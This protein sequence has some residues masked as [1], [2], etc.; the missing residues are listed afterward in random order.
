MTSGLDVQLSRARTC[1]AIAIA[2]LTALL[3]LPGSAHA[4][5]T[6]TWVAG[7]GD[8]A[9]P[10]SRTAPCKTW[11]GAISKTATGGEI[12]ALNPGGFGA[13][14]ITKSITLSAT[15]VT[16]SILVSGT[17]GIVIQAPDN[18]I[19]T[20][21]G[22]AING[23]SGTGAGGLNGIRVVQG[24]TVRLEDDNIFGFSQNG[25]DF[26]SSSP[27]ATLIVDDT[28]IS[29][30]AQDGILLAPPGAN[31]GKLL[32]S[33]SSIE[34]NG[35]G[36][37]VGLGTSAFTTANCG[38]GATGTGTVT[39]D[40]SGSS[41]SGNAGAGVAANGAGATD[42]L[43]NDVVTGNGTGL[44]P[45]NGGKIVF[46]GAGNSVFGNT[47]DGLPTS[48]Q[49]AA[50]SPGPAGANGTNGTNGTAGTN[51]TNGKVELVTCKPVT[52]TRK[53]KVHGKTRK[54]KVKTQRCTGKLVSGPVKF[55]VSGKTVHATLSRNRRV[56]ASGTIVGD[57]GRVQGLFAV[58]HRVRAGW[59]TLTTS[60]HHTVLSRRSVH[61]E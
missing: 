60:R 18:A 45:L 54:V 39:A 24:G 56:V 50:G 25:V 33:D 5:A 48:V 37:A 28:T 43:S 44:L 55:T 59:Y 49:G 51:G 10:C 21:H 6:R 61:V 40:A 15:G 26:E 58:S 35:C 30:A 52:V 20:I 16:A 31:T 3:A 12:D 46:E 47:T 41:F 42:F 9:Q 14:T 27:N 38:T 53:R 36:L 8:D 34:D 19:V 11:A 29:N 32:V 57:S 4:Q 7:D 22:I 1:A 13:V 17:N 2:L 23:I